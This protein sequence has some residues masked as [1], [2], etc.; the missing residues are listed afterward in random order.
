MIF[1][2]TPL[3]REE[4]GK[5][6]WKTMHLFSEEQFKYPMVMVLNISGGGIIIWQVF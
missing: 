3:P 5:E 1:Q 4:M 6:D 2:A